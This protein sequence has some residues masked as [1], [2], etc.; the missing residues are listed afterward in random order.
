MKNEE[1]NCTRKYVFVLQI[2][3]ENTGAQHYCEQAASSNADV[4]W[5]CRTAEYNIVWKLY[6]AGQHMR[7]IFILEAKTNYRVLRVRRLATVHT[8]VVVKVP[9]T[10]CWAE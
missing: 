7:N 5:S 3:S 6:S 4:P 2:L 1:F 8:T 9:V 10:S